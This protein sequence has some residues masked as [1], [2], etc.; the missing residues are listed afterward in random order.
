MI[1]EFY[2]NGKDAQKAWGVIVRETS[3]TALI[4][5]EPL[6]DPVENK[7][8]TEH[9]KRIRTGDEPKVD[10]R[11]VSLFIQVKAASRT[12][13][14]AKISSLKKELKKQKVELVTKYEPD[15]VYRCTYQS[16]KQTRSL[17][18]TLATFNL[19]LNEPNPNNRGIEDKDI[20]E[21]N[22]I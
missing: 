1:G 16:C 20:Y 2:I 18:K 9:G 6:K 22:D 5:P 21:N 11:T 4:E 10:E 17:F 8:A 13:L 19:Q 14:I 15:T 12:D 3:L 7:S